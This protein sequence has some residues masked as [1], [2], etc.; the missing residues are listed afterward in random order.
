M[1]DCIQSVIHQKGVEVE[2]IVQDAGSTD[3]TLDVLREFDGLIR[4]VS[5][6]DEGQS[7][8][9]NKALANATGTWIA[10]L[11]AD[12][13]YL[14]QGLATLVAH[15]E[16]TNAD[17][18][19]GETVFVD[20]SGCFER[21]LPQHRFSA[22]VLLEFGCYIAS[23]SVLM[24]REMLGSQPWDTGIRR[25]M[26]WDLY[27]Q[28]LTHGAAFSHLV[29]P[30]GAFRRHEGQV[31]NS[32][33]WEWRGEDSIVNSR[34]GLPADPFERWRRARIGRWLHPLYK[35]ADGAYWR[36]SRARGL[37]GQT[38]RWFDDE[39]GVETFGRLLDSAYRSNR[40]RATSHR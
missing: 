3:E 25:I 11:N 7:D 10:W 38:L 36:Q 34:Y 35:L 40:R 31:T 23:N 28:L 20:E 37:E 24:R 9:L 33:W 13:F 22:R 26:D 15:A 6:P 1:R 8:A 4:W 17:V 2:H 18:I 16:R 5:E 32:E 21:L 29:Y 30:V 14:P 19:Y 39:G 12:E 27:M